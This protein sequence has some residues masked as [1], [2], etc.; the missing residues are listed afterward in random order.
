MAVTSLDSSTVDDMR[1]ASP[2]GLYTPY[3]MRRAPAVMGTE[4]PWNTGELLSAGVAESDDEVTRVGGEGW[5][6]GRR[7]GRWWWWRIR[8][9]L[10]LGVPELLLVGCR[11]GRM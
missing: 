3:P 11:R 10:S 9:T 8:M 7:R 2:L 1:P 4:Q 5:S 6:T